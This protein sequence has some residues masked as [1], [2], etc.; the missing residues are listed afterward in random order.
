M[1]PN[2]ISHRLFAASLSPVNSAPA[3]R[4]VRIAV[5][6]IPKSVAEKSNLTPERRVQEWSW[7]GW[8]YTTV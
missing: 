6:T 4:P 7:S 3:K 5:K 2:S 8:H 1:N